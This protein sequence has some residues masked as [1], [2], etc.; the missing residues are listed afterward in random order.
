MKNIVQILFAV[1]LFLLGALASVSQSQTRQPDFEREAR[2]RAEVVPTIVVGDPVDIVSGERSVLGILTEGKPQ[3]AAIVLIH[4]V[5]VHP[6]FGVI[7]QLR[8]LLADAGYTTLSVQM[9]VL[10]KEVN[11]PELYQAVFSHAHERLTAA[12]TFLKNRG[13]SRLILLSHSMGSWMAND[14]LNSVPAGPDFAYSRWVNLGITGRLGS[15]G[16]HRLPI[17]DV[18]G[19]KDFPAVLNARWLRKLSIASHPGSLQVEIPGADHYYAGF[20]KQLSAVILDWLAK[21]PL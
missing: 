18:Q 2:W 4:G 5:G 21:S 3:Q 11:Q 14:Y 15:T 10:A 20:E 19:E 9:P 17:L 16:A 8:V 6:D 13:H 12:A 1:A 7:G